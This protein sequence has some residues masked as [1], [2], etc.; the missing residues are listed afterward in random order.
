MSAQ[1]FA[2]WQFYAQIEPF[3]EDRADFRAGVIA[4]TFYNMNRGKNAEALK[5]SDFMHFA[6][7][8]E[9]APATAADVH[10]KLRAWLPPKPAPAGG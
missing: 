4:S 5:P 2:D 10:A 3:G 9:R 6:E 7:K 8:P 1:E